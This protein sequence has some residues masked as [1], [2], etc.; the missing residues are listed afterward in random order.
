LSTAGGMPAA[1]TDKTDAVLADHAFWLPVA[2]PTPGS[3]MPARAQRSPWAAP[4]PVQL[5]GI[6]LPTAAA[7]TAWGLAM[8]LTRE[9]PARLGGAAVAGSG[10]SGRASAAALRAAPH[11]G[12]EMPPV[13]RVFEFVELIAVSSARGAAGRRVDADER[14]GDDEQ[15]DRE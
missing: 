8:P 2:F 9:R 3:V 11:L 5:L 7:D 1:R 4:V 15:R 10:V 14:H 6:S 13:A 12:S